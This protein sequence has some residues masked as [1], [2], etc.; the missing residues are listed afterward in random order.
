[1]TSTDELRRLLDE[2][3]V[4]YKSHYLNTSW[5]AGMKLY[6]ATD[7]MD[8]TLTVDN[9]TAEQAIAATLGNEHSTRERTCEVVNV[10]GYAFRFE[11]SLCGYVAIVHNC[12]T[13][14]DELPRYCPECG[15]RVIGTEAGE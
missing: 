4:E 14:L 13:R 11:C 2:R 8:G 15:A 9:L 7:D 6:M 3:G 5:Y 1:M 12:D 10:N